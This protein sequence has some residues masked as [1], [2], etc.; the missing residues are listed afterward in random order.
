MPVLFNLLSPGLAQG[1]VQRKSSVTLLSERMD[2]CVWT[3]VHPSH[4]KV[5]EMFTSNSI[6]STYRWTRQ[7]G[8]VMAL[9]LTL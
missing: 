5:R 7:K 3:R 1:L 2:R 8:N 9:A 6:S 4:E